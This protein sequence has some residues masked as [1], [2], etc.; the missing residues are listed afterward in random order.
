LENPTQLPGLTYE[1]I[2]DQIYPTDWRAEAINEAGEC[3]V[4]IFSGPNAE[5][6]ARQYA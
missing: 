4:V 5:E 1:V 6:R 3:Y 2:Q